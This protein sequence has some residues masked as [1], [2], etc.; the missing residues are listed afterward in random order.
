MRRLSAV[1]LAVAAV[2]LAGCAPTGSDNAATPGGRLTGI[3]WKL[4][5]LRSGSGSVPLPADYRAE[6]NFSVSGRV[7]GLN[8]P[9]A[10]DATYTTSGKTITLRRGASGAAGVAGIS[11]VKEAMDSLYLPADS[12]PNNAVVSTYTVSRVTLMINTPTWTLTFRNDRAQSADPVAPTPTSTAIR[13]D[14]RPSHRTL[15]LSCSD[16]T[17]TP[18][19]TGS[20]DRTVDGLTLEGIGGKLRGLVPAD[21][22]L[23]VPDGPALFFT[24]TPA[25]LSPGTA[26]TTIELAPGSGGYLAWVP[27][28]VWTRGGGRPVD[29]TRWMASRIVLDG[30]GQHRSTYLGGV[31]STRPGICLTLRVTQPALG[32]QGRRVRLGNAAE[33]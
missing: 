10:F 28:S 8:G 7:T 9:N 11:Q 31:L 20:G 26:A 33:C 17:S 16:S 23:R 12:V 15:E 2:V 27:A 30:C 25:Y 24:K 21:V 19:P 4:S 6:I 32:R 22:G 13:S 29:L 18:A 14:S 3:R 5:D 1:V